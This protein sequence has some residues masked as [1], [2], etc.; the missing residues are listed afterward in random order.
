M[1]LDPA[2]LLCKGLLE[3][4]AGEKVRI[5][6]LGGIWGRQWRE[7]GDSGEDMWLHAVAKQHEAVQARLGLRAC[8]CFSQH[9]EN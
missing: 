8:A 1:L 5:A 6:G 9:L 3:P 7:L 2:I 4:F